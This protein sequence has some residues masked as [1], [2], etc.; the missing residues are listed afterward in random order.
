[1]SNSNK[2]RVL[3]LKKLPKGVFNWKVCLS[4]SP[5]HKLSDYDRRYDTRWSVPDGMLEY[6]S[7]NLNG[8]YR[9]HEVK[10]HFEE[11]ENYKKYDYI[12]FEDQ[13]DV[14]MFKLCYGHHIRRIYKIEVE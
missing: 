13:L 9:L 14:T 3:K 6:L 12:L 7:H 1:M 11:K 8:K 4:I 2:P 10:G 5:G